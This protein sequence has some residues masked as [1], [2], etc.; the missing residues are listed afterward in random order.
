MCV[1]KAMLVVYVRFEKHVLLVVQ[2]AQQRDD[3]AKQQ[4]QRKVDN[5]KTQ[6]AALASLEQALRESAEV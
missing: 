4:L 2:A 6:E 3:E 5:G 1:C